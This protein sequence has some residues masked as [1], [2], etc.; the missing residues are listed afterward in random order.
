MRV[1]VHVNVCECP[2]VCVFVCVCVCVCACECVCVCFCRKLLFKAIDMGNFNDLFSVATRDI[3]P[4]IKIKTGLFNFRRKNINENYFSL[5][6]VQV[7]LDIHLDWVSIK[8]HTNHFFRLLL[9]VLL[10][11]LYFADI[12]VLCL[13]SLNLDDSA[14]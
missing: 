11:I 9:S 5:T 2:C 6:C 12:Q 8:R 1:C 14:V 7:F 3:L 10:F 13:P 4:D